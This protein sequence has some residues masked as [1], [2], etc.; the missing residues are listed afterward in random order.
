MKN[1]LKVYTVGFED[2]RFDESVTARR[3]SEYLG[4]DHQVL[5]YTLDM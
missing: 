3:I 4:V 2:P 1:D 5:T